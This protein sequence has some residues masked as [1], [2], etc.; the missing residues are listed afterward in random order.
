MIQRLDDRGGGGIEFFRLGRKKF[1]VAEID[2]QPAGGE[3]FFSR[4]QAGLQSVEGAVERLD[5][6]ARGDDA[7][8]V[9]PRNSSNVVAR[10]RRQRIVDGN[11][12]RLGILRD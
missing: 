4:L 5:V 9:E 8:D 6:A 2:G 10:K 3:L 11:G 1:L 7:L 12:Q